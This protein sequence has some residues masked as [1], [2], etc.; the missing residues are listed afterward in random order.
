M[1]DDAT[2]QRILEAA[3]VDEVISD[4]ISLK[5]RGVNYLG[6]CPFHDEK[7]PSFIVSPAK[8]I[9]KC[10][11]CGKGGNAVNFVMEHEKISYPEALKYLAKK[12]HIEVHE[13]EQTPEQIL[14]R[15]ERESL[16]IVSGFAQKYFT[17]TL[18]KTDEGK[19]IGL[20]YF[21]ERGI[22]PTMIERFKLGYSPEKRDALTKEAISRGYKKDFLVKTGLT[23]EKNEYKFD[24]FAGRVMFP[25]FNLSGKTIAFGG[26]TL[27]NDKKIAKYL[28]SPESDIYHKSDVLY[29]IFQAKTA[30]VQKNKC[31]MVEGYTDVIALHQS[32][33]EN[34][35]ASSGTSLTSNQIKLVKR[36]TNNLTVLYDGD[37]AGIKASLRGIDL[38]LEQGMN[39]K[40]LLL[41]AGEDPDSFSKKI[42][43]EQLQK[44][45]N[46]NEQDFVN[47]KIKLLKSDS[48]NDPIKRANFVNE[49]LKTVAIIPDDIIRAEYMR[50]CAKILDLQENFLYSEVNKIHQRKLESDKKRKYWQNKSVKTDI[51]PTHYHD[52]TNGTVL[53]QKND[54]LI[55]LE[56][57]IIRILL[58]HGEKVV[59]ERLEEVEPDDDDDIFNASQ[60]AVEEE[61]KK[62]SVAEYII[63]EIESEQDIFE[64]VD[65]K[66][67]KI[68]LQYQEY[69]NQ[70]EEIT[71]NRFI[72]HLDHDISQTAAD[73][74]LV[75]YEQS[76]Y[77]K[78]MG[79]FDQT[80]E[81]ILVKLVPNLIIDYKSRKIIILL[82]EIEQKLK[83][84]EDLE[85]IQALQNSYINLKRYNILLAKELGKRIITH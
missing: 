25:I 10:F 30:I 60:E 36:F 32:G 63:K 69:F 83:T 56:K 84:T 7:T 41:P 43:S 6:L 55:V 52:S 58:N 14:Q 19:A 46:E 70:M 82:Q 42:N 85:E 45:I 66:C 51:K 12:Y 22:N 53:P 77:W 4:Y 74:L 37:N 5:K 8:G 9:Y 23:I 38:I 48:E 73:M 35:V 64:F 50:D 15:N 18:N 78:R 61:M 57:E 16:L 75:K 2:I 44:F 81:E 24:R 59:L 11:G 62:V 27:K 65:E 67:K 29:G 17:K 40:I 71:T 39:V 68:Y 3:R 13:K 28:N 49:I 54:S 26:R 34:V 79:V 33:I 76:K 47:F 80:D 72:H 31:Y 1:I 20:S 21:K